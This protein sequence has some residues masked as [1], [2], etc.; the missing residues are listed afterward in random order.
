VAPL[1]NEKR[2]GLGQTAGL[3]SIPQTA[4]P[5][6]QGRDPDESRSHKEWLP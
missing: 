3:W 5:A 2:Q 6:S 1:V 4:I